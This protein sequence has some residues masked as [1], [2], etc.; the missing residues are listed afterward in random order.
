MIF[1]LYWHNINIKTRLGKNELFID[2]ST[3]NNKLNDKYTEL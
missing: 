1:L 2:L 3:V